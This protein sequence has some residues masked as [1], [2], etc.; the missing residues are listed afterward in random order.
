MAFIESLFIYP[1]KSARAIEVASVLVQSTGLQWDRH[2]MAVDGAGKFLS[3]RTHPLL[4]RIV[5]QLEDDTLLLEAPRV[6]PLRLLLQPAGAFADV[7]VWD[8]DCTGLDQGDP[9]ARWL[10]EVIGCSARIVRVV[11]APNRL[12]DAKYAGPYPVQLAFPDGFP[13]LVCNRSSL[14]SLNRRMPQPVPMERFRPNV[15]VSGLA[16]FAEDHIASLQ[17]GDVTLRLVKPST[18]CIITSTDQRTGE[19]STNPLPVLR[20]FRFDG[21]LKGVKFGENAVVARGAGTRLERGMECVPTLD[22]A[23]NPAAPA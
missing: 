20:T 8:D 5:P 13:V 3:Q 7:R 4:A 1:F 2:W 15:V 21:K 14:E 11:E 6:A 16:E 9:A 18:R 22:M 23:V 19:R 17:A 12:A 10:S